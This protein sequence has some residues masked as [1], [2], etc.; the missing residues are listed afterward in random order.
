MRPSSR[1]L[2]LT[3]YPGN[4]VQSVASTYSRLFR[5]V[6]GGERLIGERMLAIADRLGDSPDA[7][8]RERATGRPQ[9]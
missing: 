4:W 3:H 2:K 1:I 7:P 8:Q 5:S 9:F 6:P